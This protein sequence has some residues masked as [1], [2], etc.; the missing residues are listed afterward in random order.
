MSNSTNLPVQIRALLAFSRASMKL[1][2]NEDRWRA[3][4][5][6][7]DDFFGHPNV[8]GFV[9]RVDKLI[10]ERDRGLIIFDELTSVL[11]QLVESYEVA[12]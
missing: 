7:A 1:K 2:D 10:R 6:R 9:A 8:E 5:D 12:I 11:S 3:L 4:T